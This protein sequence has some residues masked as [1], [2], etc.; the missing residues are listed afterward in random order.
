[1][2]ELVASLRAA[3]AGAGLDAVGF[4]RAEFLS[5]T[6]D[7]LLSRKAAGLH[8]GM[9]FT[10]GRPERSCS[11]ETALAGARSLVVGA[12]S[13]LAPQPPRP[14]PT[15]ARVAMY[16][17]EDHYGDLRSALEE[18]ARVLRGRG[19]E[20]VVVADDNAVVD[21][22]VAQ[23][24]GLGWFGKNTNLLVGDRGSYFVLGSVVTDAELP[25]DDPVEDGCGLCRRCLPACP[26]GALVEPGVLDARRCLA[27]VLQDTGTFPVELRE[28]LG[29]RIYGCDDCQEA[30]PP[31]RVEI[32]RS[33]AES[34]S[35]P[36]AWVDV[37]EM[38]ELDDAEL[39][40]RYGSWYVPRR[41]PEYLRRNALVVL[42]NIGDGHDR[43]VEHALRSALE[44][45]EPLVVAHAVWAVRR[46]GREDLLGPVA[47]STE[48]LVVAELERPAEV[49]RPQ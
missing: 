16:Q 19:F 17:W 6:H 49:V 9:H 4:A 38:L 27:W 24:A 15:S 2:T 36:G 20:A 42:G 3:A 33:V 23:R 21:R 13:Y 45:P 10:Y 22:A 12:L 7:T 14:G 18:V 5:D 48:E 28:P 32:R 43:R 30:C 39:L 29:D 31:N 40:D 46:L 35:R 8:G 34:A 41:R 1:M 47:D 44:H 25:V 26:T 11:P 37:V